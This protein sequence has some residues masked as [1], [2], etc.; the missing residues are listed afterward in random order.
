MKQQKGFT[1]IELIVVIVILGILAATALPRFA[2]MQSDA[3]FASLNALAGS[4][5]SA[6]ALSRSA[7]MVAG[8][9]AAV[10]VSLEGQAVDVTAG[11]GATAG[12]PL[13]T[14]A[15]IGQAM[16]ALNGY[17][18]V[19][20]AGPP[21]VGTYSV[22]GAPAGCNLTYTAPAGTIA[23]VGTLATC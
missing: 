2:N 4:L 1:L 23:V 17:A 15:G 10:T 13:G 7:Y 14:A 6:V 12:V 5:R 11:N 16:G 9:A 8:N 19:Y 20:A 18:V 21:A 22:T 3:R